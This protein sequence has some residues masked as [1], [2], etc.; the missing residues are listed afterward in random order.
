VNHPF[1]VWY[2]G[3]RDGRGNQ[4]MVH[5]GIWWQSDDPPPGWVKT[6]SRTL[7]TMCGLAAF[8]L[9]S[10]EA[11]YVSRWDGLDL[12]DPGTSLCR[13]CERAY[14]RLERQLGIA[15][16]SYEAQADDRN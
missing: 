10:I 8:E 15:E 11:G 9:V 5:L 1:L 14:G 7:S 12:P 2:L 13:N 3:R 4:R 6:W 16:P